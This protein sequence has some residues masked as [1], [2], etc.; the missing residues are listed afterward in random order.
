MIKWLAFCLSL[1]FFSESTVPKTIRISIEICDNA[2]DDDQDGLIDLNDPD[3]ICNKISDSTHLLESI[4]PNASFEEYTT[5]PYDVSQMEFCKGWIQASGA[6]SDYFNTCGLNENSE[7]GSPPLP[8]PAGNGYVGFIDLSR[9]ENGV[10]AAYKEYVGTCLNK[11]LLVGKEYT[12]TFW[13][14][15][16]TGGQ[17]Y[18]ARD[19]FNLGIFA[20]DSC[21]YLPFQELVKSLAVPN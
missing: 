4:I 15:F 8:L 3:C 6:T 10:F 20:A 1:P 16:G 5:C 12:L 13:V 17:F 11:P 18:S 2:I 14:G 9:K 19:T 7:V 21:K